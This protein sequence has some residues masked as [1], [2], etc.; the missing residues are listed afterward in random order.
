[1][2]AKPTESR[3]PGPNA[4]ERPKRMN[5]LLVVVALAVVATISFALE[6]Q[7][8]PAPAPAAVP[9]VA[10]APTPVPDA[11]MAD[12][13][14]IAPAAWETAG[15]THATAPV[16]VGT[17]DAST[18]KPVVLYIG[19]LYCPY[20][21]AARWSVIAAL[22]RF[23]TF[24]GLTYSASSS[25]D[26]YPSTPTFSFY[27]GTY[28]SQYLEL[29]SVEL[30]GA[31]PIGGR[32]PTLETPTPA[33]EALI[34]KYDGPPY[35]DKA[36]AGGIPF[37]LIGGRYMWSGAPFNPGLLAGQTQADLA[38]T[39][40]TGSGA[41]AQAILANANQIT[42]AICAVTGH[43]PAAVCSS[44]AVAQAVKALPNKVP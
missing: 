15:T 13:T 16:F 42:A 19:S 10:A 30:E 23:G 38:A 26:V 17:A 28:T 39:L 22:S 31:E 21:A 44:P 34:T 40:P 8:T 25:E 2:A 37:M 12:F 14:S 18:G 5:W 7:R 43:Q 6:R 35:L 36:S 20:C 9:L 27:G 3:H 11:V 4:P 33:Q 1:M 32:Y 29:Q 41:A 24:S